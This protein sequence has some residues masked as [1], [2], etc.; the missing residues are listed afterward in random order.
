MPH[1]LTPHLGQRHFNAALLANDTA[2]FQAL[3]LAAQAFIVFDRAKNLGAKKTVAL[4]LEGTVVN[5]FRLFN[6]A[7]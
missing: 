3:V 2:V 4:W 6:F 7:E 5:G 1:A